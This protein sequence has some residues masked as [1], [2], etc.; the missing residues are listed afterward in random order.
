MLTRRI[1]LRGTAM[2]PVRSRFRSFRVQLLDRLY[3]PRCSRAALP[4]ET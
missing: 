4:P 1:F 2:V 3:V